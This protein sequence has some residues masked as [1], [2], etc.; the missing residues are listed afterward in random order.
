MCENELKIHANQ[1]CT[2]VYTTIDQELLYWKFSVFSIY[3]L[4]SFGYNKFC[5]N[6]RME[7]IHGNTSASARFDDI[8]RF[9][10]SGPLFSFL[11]RTRYERDYFSVEK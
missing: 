1:T 6:S 2:R 5:P 7:G 9:P 10:D 3:M 4:G 8:V 11:I